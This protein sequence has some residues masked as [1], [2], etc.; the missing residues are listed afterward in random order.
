MRSAGPGSAPPRGRRRTVGPGA[1]AASRPVLDAG[2]SP[3]ASSPAA[4]FAPPPMPDM[5]RFP[6]RRALPLLL[7]SSCAPAAARA[8]PGAQRRNGRPAAPPGGAPGGGGR[9]AP[10]H[11]C[12][13]VGG[14]R[15][16]RRRLAGA[17]A[18][19]DRPLRRGP[20]HLRGD[21][22]ARPHPRAA[23]VA[24]ARRR[25]DGDA[26]AAR[27]PR[28]PARAGR[29]PA[30]RPR[31]SA[32][33]TMRW[34]RCSTPTA[35]HAYSGATPGDRHQP[36][37]PD[38]RDPRGAPAQGAARRARADARLQPPR[39]EREDARGRQR[40]HRGDRAAGARLRR[41]PV[42]RRGASAGEAGR[43]RW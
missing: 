41:V 42:G 26:G 3:A 10:L 9:R 22:R 18:R 6:A 15:A 2:A 12:R 1:K 16:A 24:D 8:S 19:G 25:A 5:P 32:R 4:S 7:L 40:P 11:S 28:L 35:P 33:Y 17:A 13:A 37:R 38:A 23:L 36:R 30:R 39:P 29:R 21:V 27:H 14:A 31:S 20:S 34:S 43:R